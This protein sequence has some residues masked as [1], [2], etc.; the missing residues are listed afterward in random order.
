MQDNQKDAMGP[1]TV[2][3][4]EAVLAYLKTNPDFLLQHPEVLAPDESHGKGVE[5]FLQA[6]LARLRE[7][8]PF[9]AEDRYFAPDIAAAK[10]MVSGT[11]F[12]ALVGNLLPSIRG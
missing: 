6:G 8:V 9:Y 4:E 2:L 1:V 11:D 12:H 5:S 7:R 3:S 10:E